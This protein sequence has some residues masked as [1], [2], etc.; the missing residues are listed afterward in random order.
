MAARG[1]IFGVPQ[2]VV[3]DGIPR[4]CAKA[5]DR[6]TSTRVLRSFTPGWQNSKRLRSATVSMTAEGNGRRAERDPIDELQVIDLIWLI[7]QKKSRNL[8]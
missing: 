2:G 3:G 8:A 4:R 6:A 7:C 5:Q 1:D